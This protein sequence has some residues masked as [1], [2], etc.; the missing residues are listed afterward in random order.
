[1]KL[2]QSLTGVLA[3]L[4]GFIVGCD[5]PIYNGNEGQRTTTAISP[6]ESWRASG[7]LREA[8]KAVDGDLY[9]AA[10]SADSYDNAKLTLDLG[11]PCVFNT[12][13]LDHSQRYQFG[14]CR[15]VS[16]LI[17]NDGHNFTQVY[18]GPGTRRVTYLNL[19]TP[20]LARYVRLQVVVPG[21]KPWA[22]AEIYLQ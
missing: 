3:I 13:I 6:R 11:K 10:V 20:T 8:A 12:I 9:S 5:V 7:D 17:S 2:F 19:I 21:D 14:F 16:V 18:V 15:R 22:I 4:L 1:M